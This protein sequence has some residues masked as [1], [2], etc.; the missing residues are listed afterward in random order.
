MSALKGVIAATPTPLNPDLTIDTARL[1]AHCRWLLD[2]G[3]CDA[4]NLLGTTGEA[5]SFSVEQRIATMRAVAKSGL[6]MVRIM[7]GTGAAS[8]TDAI[9]LT[10]AA[11]D[12]GF[13]GALLL[14]A[15]Y[16]KGIDAE[17][18]IEYVESVISGA[19]APGMKLYLYHI[20]QNTG[21][22]YPIEAVEALHR[23]HPETVVGLKDSSGDIAYSR[24]LAAKLP[25]FAVFPSAEGSLAEAK[26]AGFAGC[27][28]ATTN[29]TGRLAQIAWS[30]PA[31]AQQAV[32]DATAIRA[33]LSGYPLVASVKAALSAMK[34][35]PA[36][37][38]CVPPIRPLTT[39]QRATLFAR[40]ND[41]EFR[42]TPAMQGVRR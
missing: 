29:V 4:V 23:R 21:V 32:A 30:D 36:W 8:L 42:N 40:L 5:T 11:H 10:L 34:G 37:E 14:P 3:G 38:R 6:P 13:A 20:P 19:G 35:D 39:E 26:S 9:T 27:I 31:S 16:Y 7:V 41:T 12:L 17:S 25:G 2:E 22:P 33:A 15:F 1:I 24:S 28:S 18:V